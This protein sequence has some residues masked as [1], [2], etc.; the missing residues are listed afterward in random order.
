MEVK[1]YVGALQYQDQDQT[2]DTSAVSH[3]MKYHLCRRI[4]V[5]QNPLTIHL[6]HVIKLS[7]CVFT[8][9]IRLLPHVTLPQR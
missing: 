6:Q 1:L 8:G 2:E 5:E 3:H 9:Y 7:T 4:Q